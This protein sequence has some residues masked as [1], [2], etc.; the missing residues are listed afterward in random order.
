MKVK[1][2]GQWVCSI[3][4]EPWETYYGLDN[5]ESA[6]CASC[7]ARPYEDEPLFFYT[8]GRQNEPNG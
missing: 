1:I 8:W 7:G 5:S 6:Q 3:C 2:E 4:G